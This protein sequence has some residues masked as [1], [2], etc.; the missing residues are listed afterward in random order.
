ML[1][2]EQYRRITVVLRQIESG[3]FDADVA[4]AVRLNLVERG[5]RIH[6]TCRVDSGWQFVGSMAL[7]HVDAVR[8]YLQSQLDGCILT[9]FIGYMRP[10]YP[11][12]TLVRVLDGEEKNRGGYIGGCHFCDGMWEYDVHIVSTG[13]IHR[14]DEVQLG[15]WVD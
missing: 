13:V 6:R 7:T 5:G 2:F 15:S 9:F 1:A 10:Y 12:G 8:N 3:T 14:Y 11:E 4:E